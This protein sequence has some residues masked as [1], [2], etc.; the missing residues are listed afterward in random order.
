ML[1]L[2]AAVSM[3][4]GLSLSWFWDAQHPLRLIRG[5]AE[6]PEEP[7]SGVVT[8]EGVELVLRHEWPDGQVGRIARLPLPRELVG[9]SPADLM[10]ARPQWRVESLDSQQLVV[11][12]PC[13][14]GEEGFLGVS[15]G[16]VAVYDGA[17]DG[18]SRLREVTD[19]PLQDLPSFQV[20]DL[21]RGIPFR[22][23]TELQ[24]ILEGLRVP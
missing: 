6:A 14:E 9:L 10:A 20:N 7:W 1:W 11:A 17:P 19:I 2:V 3:L 24:L 23:E 21:R 4:A 5:R 13:Q 12:L 18:C 16:F 22:D 8:G 15:G